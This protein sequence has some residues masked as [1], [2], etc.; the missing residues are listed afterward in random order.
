MAKAAAGN[1]SLY[2]PMQIVNNGHTRR[3]VCP[4]Q[5]NPAKYIYF[6]EHCSGY[7]LYPNA[8]WFILGITMPLRLVYRDSTLLVLN[9]DFYL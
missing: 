8:A 3:H 9:L 6:H 1:A 7:P 4:L 5:T 2:Y